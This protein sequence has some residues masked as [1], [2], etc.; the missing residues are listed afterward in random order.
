MSGC[1]TNLLKR[2]YWIIKRPRPCA[3]AFGQFEDPFK[4]CTLKGGTGW[5]VQ[6]ALEQ[7]KTFDA[8]QDRSYNCIKTTFVFDMY[9]KAWFELVPILKPHQDT[10]TAI[11]PFA[12]KRFYGAPLLNK[13]S[14]VVGSRSIDESTRISHISSLSSKSTRGKQRITMSKKKMT[15]NEQVV[16]YQHIFGTFFVAQKKPIVTEVEIRQRY[17]P[18]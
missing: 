15:F 8:I 10:G 5:T 7:M 13:E 17:S 1:T 14:A 4:P 3:Y 9:Y 11:S 2:N 16:V 6:L 12:F 18:F